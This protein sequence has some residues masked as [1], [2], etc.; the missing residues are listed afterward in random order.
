[1]RN[2]FTP[3]FGSTPPLLVGRQDL[4]DDFGDGLDNGPGSPDRAS[5]YTGARG[6]GKTV[7]LNAVDDQARRH[8]WVVISETALPGLLHR[9]IA[10]HFPA[11]LRQID[12]RTKS[13]R[14]NA[15]GA[16]APV[17]GVSVGWENRDE[18]EVTAGLRTHIGQVTDLLARH[19]AGLLIT[20]DEI[21]RGETDALRLLGAE[22]QHAIR[23]DREIAFVGAGLPS[24][25]GELLGED[26]VTFLRR[27]NRHVL[28]AVDDAEVAEALRTP[29]EEHGRRIGAEALEAAT[30]AA[31]GYP[32]LIQLVGYH[33]WRQHP[34][35]L[36]ITRADVEVGTVAAARRMGS[37]IHEPSLTPVSAVGRTFLLAMAIDD[38]PSRTGDIAERLGVSKSY[39]GVYRQRLLDSELIR[40][41]GW[42]RVDFNLPYLRDYLREHATSMVEVGA[43]EPSAARR[44]RRFQQGRTKR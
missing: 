1:M 12:P 38:G 29:I 3:T 17:G 20:I 28:G 13:R 9:L 15:F 4:I 24:A 25:V 23:E 19:G 42:G 31:Q 7:M 14:V 32:F 5:L 36:Q 35:R 2:P 10:E 8:G 44:L 18:H 34:Q 27:A 30:L 22:L 41:A 11:L 43:I 6:V 26:G 37:L 21:H 16:N 39:A 33:I 40:V